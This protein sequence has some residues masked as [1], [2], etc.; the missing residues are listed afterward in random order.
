MNCPRCGKLILADDVNLDRLL[1]KCRACNEVF[2]F[3]PADCAA[4]V[5]TLDGWPLTKAAKP[6]RIKIVETGDERCLIRAWHEDAY[7]LG[8]AACGLWNGGLLVWFY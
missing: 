5:Q 3:E 1:A 8:L 4:H 2:R 7:F 6:E